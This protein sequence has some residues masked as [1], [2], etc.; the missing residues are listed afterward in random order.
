MKF[1]VVLFLFLLSACA[2]QSRKQSFY[3]ILGGE[4]AIAKIADEVVAELHSD[5]R[6]KDLFVDTDDE[7][8]KA[9]LREHL[10]ELTG[11]GCE[12]TGLAMEEAHSGLNLTEAQFNYFVD[13]N[14]RGMT[15]AGIS[16]ANQNRL[17]AILAP[18]RAQII[19]Q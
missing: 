10:C 19:H 1:V 3:D 17:L 18:M 15:K 8:F 14:R 12:Y 6:L 5:V 16:I 9:R 11:G 2:Q 4:Q 7:Y 13:A